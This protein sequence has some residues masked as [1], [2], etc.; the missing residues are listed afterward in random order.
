[1]RLDTQKNIAARLNLNKKTVSLWVKRYI[2]EGNCD[3]KH[4]QNYPKS[5]T[6]EEDHEIQ[7]YAAENPLTTTVVI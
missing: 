2:E 6:P 5:T 4:R 7:Q 1:M 3:V